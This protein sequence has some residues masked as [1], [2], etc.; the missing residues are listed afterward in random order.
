M[1]S[2]NR[3]KTEFNVNSWMGNLSCMA[4]AD[5]PEYLK[6]R[7]AEFKEMLHEEQTSHEMTRRKM[8]AE[9]YRHKKEIEELKS[10]LAYYRKNLIRAN[11]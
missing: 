11:L 8:H 5:S 3:M 6:S 9:E 1:K 4:Y 10:Y 2:S 7:I